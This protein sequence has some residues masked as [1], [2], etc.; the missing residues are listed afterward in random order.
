MSTCKYL[1]YGNASTGQTDPGCAT[2][3]RSHVIT[4]N[5]PKTVQ[6]GNTF[7]VAV[8]PEDG[9]N[10]RQK[11][12]SKWMLEHVWCCIGRTTIKEASSRLLRGG[13]LQSQLQKTSSHKVLTECQLTYRVFNF[14]W[15]PTTLTIPTILTVHY[16]L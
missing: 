13:S 6:A 9:Q 11:S 14:G 7:A 5:G 4:V 10:Y 8:S 15:I 1:Y 12:V 16:V 2:G 3:Y